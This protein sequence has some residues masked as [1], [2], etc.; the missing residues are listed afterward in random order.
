MSD[1]LD[2]ELAKS[3]RLMNHG[4]TVLVSSAHNGKQ[5]VMAAA[6][7]MPLDFEPAKV[8]VIVAK[9]TFTRQLIDAS[10]EF[11][12]N[13]HCK[14]QAAQVLQVGSESG[15]DVDKFAQSGLQPIAAQQITAP[16]VA[17]CIAYLECKI[18]T[19]P[20]NQ[21]LYDLYIGEVVAAQAHA[22]VFKNGHWHFEGHDDLRTLHYVA[23]GSFFSIGEQFEVSK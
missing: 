4:P 23:G 18:I 11:I 3:Y 13:I 5:N 1:F 20:R 7:A 22:A 9:D 8:I 17:G 21:D 10:G 6:W 14:K 12:L 19:E 2:V 16:R 15:N